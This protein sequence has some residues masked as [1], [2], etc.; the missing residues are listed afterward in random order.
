MTTEK[1]PK[2]Y[3]IRVLATNAPN[4]IHPSDK[5]Y[6][7]IEPLD[8]ID[9]L[10]MD[11]YLGNA[12]KYLLRAGRKDG[13]SKR[14]DLE[15]LKHYAEL[16][17]ARLLVERPLVS[18]EYIAKQSDD[19]LL[20]F[21]SPSA[22]EKVGSVCVGRVAAEIHRRARLSPPAIVPL[23]EPSI[24]QIESEL[25]EP[26]PIDKALEAFTALDPRD[27]EN[28]FVIVSNTGPGPND[29]EIT[30]RD[31]NHHLTVRTL[32][33]ASRYKS[34]DEAIRDLSRASERV[35]TLKKAIDATRNPSLWESIFA[36]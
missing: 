36:P 32:S 18:D 24:T 26:R 23:G 7:D 34:K 10:D 11:F 4:H 33:W 5:T 9:A 2:H 20:S 8:I 21:L 35:I 27:A 3:A 15:K 22:Q 6:V 30:T 19:E 13:Q 1:T 31:G 16:A 14:A 17:I 25:S 29:V 12:L 28:V